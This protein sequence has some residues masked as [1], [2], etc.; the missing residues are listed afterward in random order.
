MSRTAGELAQYLE[1]KLSGDSFLPISGVASPEQACFQDVIYIES[2]RHQKRAAGS[3]AGCVLARPG[4]R[5]E[6]K[7]IVETATPKLAFAK[8]SA[9][10]M[11]R[12][13]VASEI[14]PTAVVAKSAR[15]GEQV[16]LGPYVVVEEDARIGQ[17]TRVDAF[18]FVGC[19]AQLGENCRLHPRVTLYPGIR[20]G[21][22]VEIHSGSVIGGDGF[23]YVFGEGRQWKF[24]QIGTLEIEDDVEVGCNTTIDRG[25]LGETYIGNGVKIDNLVQVAHNV[26]IGAHSV[27]AAQTGISGSTVLGKRVSVGGQAGFGEHALVEDGVNVGGQAGVLGRKTV[28][29]GET[30]WGTPSRPLGK[31]KEHYAWSA[32]LPD[33]LPD[34]IARVE[35]LEDMSKKRQ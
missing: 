7:T 19:G 1:A 17:G 13:P 16:S 23:G 25:S 14:H 12:Q 15:L 30:V 34:L 4:V 28:R 29:T 27:I 10:L 3:K 20:V 22:R 11:L 18:C 8:A 26:Q 2:P 9:W 31:F 33:L 35:K 5:I 21:N 6:G 24:P 32:R